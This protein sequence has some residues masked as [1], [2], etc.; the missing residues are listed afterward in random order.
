MK[1]GDFIYLFNGAGTDSNNKYPEQRVEIL[2]DEVVA[3]EVIGHHTFS[4]SFPVLVEV[5]A[6]FCAS[7][8]VLL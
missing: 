5:S 4:S 2:D 1:F 8:N 7:E 3:T 6:D